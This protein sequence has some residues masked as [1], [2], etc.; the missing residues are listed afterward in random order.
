M[1]WYLEIRNEAKCSGR[2]FCQIVHEKLAEPPQPKTKE[3]GDYSILKRNGQILLTA[4]RLQKSYIKR[5]F[6]LEKKRVK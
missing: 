2:R 5:S 1:T 3:A 4:H 6:V